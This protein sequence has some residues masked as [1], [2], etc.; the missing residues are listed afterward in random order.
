MLTSAKIRSGHLVHAQAPAEALGHI[1]GVGG[2]EL[3]V[4][5]LQHGEFVRVRV[6]SNEVGMAHKLSLSSHLKIDIINE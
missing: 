6:M 1:G 3:E 5:E 4:V 2:I